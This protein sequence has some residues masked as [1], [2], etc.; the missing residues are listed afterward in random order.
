LE[1]GT[2]TY[3]P[4][5]KIMN[6]TPVTGSFY[7]IHNIREEDEGDFYLDIWITNSAFKNDVVK[8]MK[9]L[10]AETGTKCCWLDKD[11]KKS[12]RSYFTGFARIIEYADYYKDGK[13]PEYAFKITEGQIENGKPN[14]FAR[15]IDGY[16]G[17]LEFGYWKN[18]LM[19][20]TAD[21]KA[22]DPELLK[23]IKPEGYYKDAI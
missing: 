20:K 12:L 10:E 21:G 17:E 16:T 18:G 13:S 8:K 3:S 15:V 2:P 11:E 1:D 14:G 5:V 6:E 9:E 22:I 23:E 4:L 19:I 7:K